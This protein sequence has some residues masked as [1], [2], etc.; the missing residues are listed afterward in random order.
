MAVYFLWFNDPT[1][2]SLPHNPPNWDLIRL[3]LVVDIVISHSLCTHE[4]QTIQNVSTQ[5]LL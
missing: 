4:R 5:C 1:G 2:N 3:E